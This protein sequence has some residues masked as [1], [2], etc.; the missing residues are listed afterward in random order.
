MHIIMPYRSGPRLRTRLNLHPSRHHKKPPGPQPHTP[1]PP[2]PPLPPR[3]IPL[4]QHPMLHEER[5]RTIIHIKPPKRTQQI[6]TPLRPDHLPA[7]NQN[8]RLH[9]LQQLLGTSCKD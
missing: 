1:P 7:H 9:S 5:P 8:L 3:Y 2:P 4:R 6:P